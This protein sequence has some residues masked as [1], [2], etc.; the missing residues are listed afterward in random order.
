MAR[1]PASQ[2]ASGKIPDHRQR[3]RS[4]ATATIWDQ[5]SFGA[6]RPRPLRSPEAAQPAPAL[7]RG[8]CAAPIEPEPEAQLIH[9][10]VSTVGSPA[11]HAPEPVGDRTAFLAV[12]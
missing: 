10:N 2:I 5:E 7:C 11:R 3:W 12:F 4:F 6:P 9:F 8:A 1:R